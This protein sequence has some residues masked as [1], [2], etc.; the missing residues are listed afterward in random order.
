MFVKRN[1]H[2]PGGIVIPLVQ[3]GPAEQTIVTLADGRRRPAFMAE[4]ISLREHNPNGPNAGKDPYL[5]GGIENLRFTT[6]RYEDVEGLDFE[7][8]DKKTGETRALNEETLVSRVSASMQ[9]W[10]AGR[11]AAPQ[12]VSLDGDEG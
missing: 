7:V 3:I 4:V 11:G 2:I 6:P 10:Q 1:L 9:A 5:Q 8:I 12:V